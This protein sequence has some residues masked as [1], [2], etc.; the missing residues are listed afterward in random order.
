MRVGPIVDGGLAWLQVVPEIGTGRALGFV[1]TARGRLFHWVEV[2]DGR[3]ARYRT[4]APT[5]WNFHPSGPLAEGLV[6][7]AADDLAMTRQA[8]DLFVTAVD[9]CVGIQ[10]EIAE[11]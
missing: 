8:V 5:E 11:A 2:R 1:D 3:V 10:L 4:L 7:A 9:P 6:G